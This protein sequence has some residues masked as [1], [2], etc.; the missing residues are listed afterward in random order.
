MLIFVTH[1]ENTSGY[2]LRLTFNTGEVKD[3]DFATVYDSGI[4]TKLKDKEYFK[5]F[6]LDGFSVDW[7]NEVGLAPEYLYEHGVSVN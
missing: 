2:V 4:L 6:R 3:F 5:H 1:A 7:N